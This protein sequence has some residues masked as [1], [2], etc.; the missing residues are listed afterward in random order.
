MELNQPRAQPTG[1]QSWLGVALPRR[2]DARF[3]TGAAVYAADV[4]PDGLLH[5]A[6]VRSPIASATGV[7][8]DVGPARDAPGVVAAFTADD[9]DLRDIPGRGGPGRP[10]APAMTR[11][12]L[13]R[14]RVR[15]LGEPAAV[16]VADDPYAAVDAAE[17]VALDFTEAPVVA[18]AAAALTDE[19][20]LFP[21]AG[22]NVVARTAVPDGATPALDRWPVRAAVE[23]QEQRLAPVPIEPVSIVAAP[24]GDGR[25]TVWCGHQAP[26]RL[27]RQLAGLLGIDQRRIR[28]VVP[29]VGGAFGMKSMLYP[30]YPVVAA[31][32]LR[33][34]RPVAWQQTRYEQFVSGTHGR[35]MRHRVELAGEPDGR[36]RA[37]RVEIL[38]DLGAYPHNGSGVPLFAQLLAQGA[39]DIAD[40]AVATTMV[41]TNRAQTGP[42]RGAGRPDANFAME[43]AV[44][45]FA[46]RVG[47]DPAEVRRRNLV[48]PGQMPYRTATGAVYDGGDY[49]EALARA[50]ELAGE[51]AVRAEQARRRAAGEDPVGLGIGMFVERAGGDAASTEYARVEVDANGR[52]CA[53]VGSSAT[54]QG[55]QTVYGQIVASALGIRPGDVTVVEGDTD[56]VAAG[57]GSFASRSA[58]VGGS[59]LHVVAQRVRDCACQLAGRLLEVPPAELVARPG[60]GYGGPGGRQVTL[61]EIAAH[62][63]RHGIELAAEETWSPGAQ[64]FPY[65][66]C[67]AVVEVE[68]DTGRVLLRRLVA[69]DDCGRLLNPLI[70][71]GQLQGSLLQGVAQALYEGIEYDESAQPL[72]ASLA[73]YAVPTAPDAP[74]YHTA[75]LET[76][77]PSNPLGVK[78]AGESGCIGAPPAV[79]NAVLDAL[80]PDGVTDLQMP[81]TPQ[82]V[83]RRLHEAT[84]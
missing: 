4:R 54:G 63:H 48:R 14:D 1:P 68:R 81:L 25:L 43:R 29:D 77:A 9:L 46:R 52:V 26:H 13:A 33:L 82:Q 32:A 3:V 12:P 30:E 7:T 41:V 37:A 22:T 61:A 70:V 17:L 44:D 72:N 42:Y 60:G 59:A 56:A 71:E 53:R 39:Y 24:G 34:G 31:A 27:R 20:L 55:H 10:E 84:G 15:Y 8:A 66:A 21:A 16:V 35:A 76:P 74:R 50:L 57:T 45:A 80:A 23:I 58:Q 6:F 73:D 40:L 69:V 64:T 79:V 49:P 47:L 11:P 18:T 75:H 19:V 2:E 51:P 83:W 28:V 78:G 38:A 5:A 36:I 62:A 67:V 65:G